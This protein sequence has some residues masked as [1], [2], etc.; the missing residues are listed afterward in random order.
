MATKYNQV[1]SGYQSY[2]YGISFFQSFGYYL[3]LHHQEL[4]DLTITTDKIIN[5]N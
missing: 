5:D 1:F 3:C 4:N 2:K